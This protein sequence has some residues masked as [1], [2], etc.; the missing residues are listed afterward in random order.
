MN[1]RPPGAGD[2]Q[3]EIIMPNK[4][5]PQQTLSDWQ[6]TRD[7]ITRYAQVAGKIRRALTP[8]QKHW[9]H[10][11]LRVA[12]SGL[13][14]TPISAG[15]QTFELLLDFTHHRLLITTSRGKRRDF[16]LG[17][18]SVNDFLKQT[19]NLLAELGI[20]PE[21]DQE[22]F[23]STEAGAYDKAAVAAYWQAL[24]QIDVTLKE[25]RH[26]FRGESSPVQ[27]WPHHF[28]LAVVWFSG[29]LIP[30]QDPADPEWSDEQMN[31]GFSTGDGSIPEPYFYATAYPTPDGWTDTV[32]P[33][34][35]YWQ[36]A[37]FTG[38]ILPYAAV[39][40][41]DDGRALLLD[42]LNTSHQAGQA[43]IQGS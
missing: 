21:I 35:A 25:F 5:F 11:S 1:S 27:L 14:T 3:K 9:W 19:L 40:A 36:T 34:A 41:S 16:A 33:D 13:T 24:S 23:A 20:Q 43:L 38:A 15:N 26:T 8:H 32:L 30:D 28:D 17:G 2:Q 31:F 22:S 29:R 12:A 18:Q 37:G 42:F 4:E 10:A 39:A 6:P 7:T